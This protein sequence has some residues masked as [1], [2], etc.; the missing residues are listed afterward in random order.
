MPVESGV[1]VGLTSAITV[2]WSWAIIVTV[3]A[4]RGS[5]V[6]VGTPAGSSDVGT[7]GG[8][9]APGTPIDACPVGTG[10]NPSVVATAASVGNLVAAAEWVGVAE[11]SRDGVGVPACGTP[12]SVLQPASEVS[13]SSA[14]ARITIRAGFKPV[15]PP[16]RRCAGTLA[17]YV[18]YTMLSRGR[19]LRRNSRHV[20]NLSGPC[21]GAPTLIVVQIIDHGTLRRQ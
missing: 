16:L 20:P 18:L 2:A 21:R 11:I 19:A 1:V 12:C 4:S 6:G 3:G 9:C 8:G 13:T 7:A 10:A 17:P 14:R 15:H 5:V